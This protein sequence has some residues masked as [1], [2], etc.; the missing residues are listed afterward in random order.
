MNALTSV[1]RAHGMCRASASGVT[2]ILLALILTLVA[3]PANAYWTAG[4]GTASASTGTLTAP[5]GVTA[6]ETTI[7][8]VALSW[9]VGNGGVTP[10]G[11]YVTRHVAVGANSP[12]IVEPACS[13]SPTALLGG[14]TCNDSDVPDGDYTYVVTAVFASWTAPS[15]PS[16][17]VS[18]THAAALAFTAQPTD[19][20][21][22][23]AMTPPVTVALRTAGD[24]PLASAG[25]P[26]TLAIGANPAVGVLSGVVT[27]DTDADG[28]VSFPGLS[29]DQPG[30]G[31]SLVATGTGLVAATSGEF[32][33]TPAPLLGVAANY[34]VLAGTAV[35]STGA[36][37][38]SG[39]VGVSPGTA[40]TGLGPDSVGGDIHAGDVD[41]AR[42]QHAMALAYAELAALPVGSGGELVGDLGGR[43]ITPGNYHSTAALALT[44]V[45]I[46]DAQNNPDAVF[47]FQADAAFDMAAASSMVLINGAKASNIYWIVNG[48]TGAGADALISGNILS[49]GAITLGMGTVLTGRALSRAT[50]T[51]AGNTIRF[52]TALPPTMTI[53]GGATAVTKDLTPSIAGTSSAPA[54]SPVTVTLAGQ[55]LSTTVGLDDSWAVTATTVAVGQ[56]D[57]IAKVG[58]PG[59]DGTAASQVLTVEVSPPSVDLGM[60]A[61]FSVLGSTGVVST[62]STHLSGDLGVSPSPTVTGFG[63]DEGGSLEGTIHAADDTASAARGDLVS[64]LDDASS[65]S[66]HTEIAGDLD[67]RTFHVGVHHVTAALALT[68]TV[69][70]DGEGDPEGVFIFQT[71]AAFNTA[72]GSTVILLNGAQAANVF[73]VV[74]GAASTGAAS[75]L[76]GSILARGA[77]TLG[78]GTNLQGQ[79]LSL[80]T[81][82]LASNILT[83]IT[84]ASAAPRAMPRSAPLLSGDAW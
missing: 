19:V 81:V 16:G 6:P 59:H 29:I 77:I 38:V 37:T 15:R 3:G 66:R 4:S 62:G 46:I 41:A 36:A 64:A 60:T 24:E 25:V 1:T 80:G 48:A 20:A 7:A 10:S 69:T 56:Y 31:Y 28:E 21:A 83:G 79:A 84:P 23:Q 50:V 27:R 32:A 5:A 70:L 22:E 47:V 12:A 40:I 14:L 18:V 58:A 34:S 53:T 72:A 43:T 33:V 76:A 52:S 57:V 17:L 67:G 68:G 61:T 63:P 9:S 42:A 74:T 45:L 71:D 75:N 26:V 11:Y 2:F 44:G 13:S 82:T 39:D 51:L 49:Q 73:W 54:S 30:A 65:R 35:V 8:G 78:A 55:T